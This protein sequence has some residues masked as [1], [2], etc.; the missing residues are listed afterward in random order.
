MPFYAYI[1][2]NLTI[3]HICCNFSTERRA[4][5]CPW[6]CPAERG[7]Q[8]FSLPVKG[9]LP[10]N[11]LILSLTVSIFLPARKTYRNNSCQAPSTLTCFF[12]QGKNELSTKK[13]F[14]NGMKRCPKQLFANVL[15]ICLKRPRSHVPVGSLLLE[16]P[17]CLAA[18]DK[19]VN[20]PHN[21]SWSQ[22]SFCVSSVTIKIPS[23]NPTQLFSPCLK[24]EKHKQA[25]LMQK[26]ET[27]GTR[28]NGDK[29]TW[30]LALFSTLPPL[31]VSGYGQTLWCLCGWDGEPNKRGHSLASDCFLKHHALTSEGKP[32]AAHGDSQGDRG[33]ALSQLRG[34]GALSS[35]GASGSEFEPLLNETFRI[36][37]AT[38]WAWFVMSVQVS[39]VCSG[40]QFENILKVGAETWAQ[41]DAFLAGFPS[42]CYV[43]FVPN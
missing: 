7:H 18:P 39:G 9:L 5:E 1:L 27:S 34:R 26:G 41:L 43:L 19:G 13:W 38:P 16:Q 20:C 28:I 12:S 21:T 40:L 17:A 23:S 25:F 15:K 4:E 14:W 6:G 37:G 32:Q 42:A 2:R 3:A 10:I 22:Q 31:R 8:F 35:A 33:C 11:K 24:K 29:E 30:R 36:T